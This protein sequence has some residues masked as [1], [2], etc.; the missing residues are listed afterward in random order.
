MRVFIT[1]I[2]GF[3]GNRLCQ[4]L[5]YE[6]VECAGL[7]R[8]SPSSA[9]HA[10]HWTR[11]DC[12]DFEAVSGALD[13]FEPDVIVHC[14]MASGHPQ[15]APERTEALRTGVLGTASIV[16]A[17]MH[18]GRARLVHAGSFLV[19]EPSNR[20][21]QES[22]PL[23]PLTTRGVAKAGAELVVQQAAATSAL[24]AIV[25]RIF[26]VYGPGEA[27]QRFIPTLIR[28]LRSDAPMSLTPWPRRDF[29]HV[30]DVVSAITR[31]MRIA[32]PSGSV[33][34]VGS[35]QS[36]SNAE[37]VEL[38]EAASGRRLRTTGSHPTSPVDSQLWLADLALT[39]R[40]LGWSPAISLAQGLTAMYQA[41]A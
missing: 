22:S 36:H 31:A 13:A 24:H 5:S 35:G 30:D 27:A 16:D 6:G 37:V 8:R 15:S 32:A 18:Y 9:L 40:V 11:A 33:F 2:S 12:T 7:S 26:S 1:G 21:L 17:A 19:Y 14:A 41:P 34:N 23:R 10:A 38:A 3:I 20:P 39:N 28:S 25:L 29:V 4:R